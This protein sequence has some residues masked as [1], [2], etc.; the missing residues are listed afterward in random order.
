MVKTGFTNDSW[1]TTIGRINISST[2]YFVFFVQ[3]IVI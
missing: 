3:Y 1:L 2:Y